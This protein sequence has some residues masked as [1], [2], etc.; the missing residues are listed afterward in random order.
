MELRLQGLMGILFHECIE[1]C[2]IFTQLAL[3]RNKKLSQP[4]ETLKNKLE[5]L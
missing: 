5:I 2:F 3:D 4:T 1:N